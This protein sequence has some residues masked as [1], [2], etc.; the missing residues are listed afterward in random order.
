M[1]ATHR[2][3]RAVAGAALALLI[4]RPTEAVPITF[5]FSVEVTHLTGFKPGEALIGRP[6]AVGDTLTG[7]YTFDSV[8]SWV[9]PGGPGQAFYYFAGAPYGFTIDGG[10]T[11]T[12]LGTYVWNKDPG[13]FPA[14]YYEVDGIH[15]D[16]PGVFGAQMFITL[17]DF[18]GNAFPDESLPLLP[19]SLALFRPADTDFEIRGFGA[20]NYNVQ[21]TVTSLR[22]VPEP[23]TMVLL[24]SGLV[25]LSAR[26]R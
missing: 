8:P 4:A 9:S 26:W 10:P 18:S 2:V 20:D 24:G 16:T 11:A 12:D 1:T 13:G 7:S 14:D 17:I 25:A 21:G 15:L 5:N 23:A 3:G 6:V 22:V 19:P